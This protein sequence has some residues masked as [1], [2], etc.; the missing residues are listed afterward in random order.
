MLAKDHF[1]DYFDALLLAIDMQREYADPKFDRDFAAFREKAEV[2]AKNIS[3]GRDSAL[4]FK[5][6]IES[7]PRMTIQF[8]QA[9]RLLIDA[10]TDRVQTF[11]ETERALVNVLAKND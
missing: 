9:K 3:S 1:A 10:L 2:L 11:D 7:L 6:T 4:S 8:N 5:R